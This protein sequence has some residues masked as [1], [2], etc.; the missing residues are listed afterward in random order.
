MYFYSNNNNNPPSLLWKLH[1]LLT[2]KNTQMCTCDYTSHKLNIYNPSSHHGGMVHN[3]P[4]V[5]GHPVHKS[6]RFCT[7]RWVVLKLGNSWRI[8]I[9]W[10]SPCLTS[11][12]K[13]CRITSDNA[14]KRMSVSIQ[15]NFTIIALLLVEPTYLY[16]KVPFSN[17]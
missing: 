10:P 6:C 2:N 15:Q 16:V 4:I 12:K 17:P 13:K 14:I 3:V 9:F 7:T 5:I 1:T 11:G 8:L